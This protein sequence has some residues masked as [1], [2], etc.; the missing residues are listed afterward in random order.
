[1]ELAEEHELFSKEKTGKNKD[2]KDKDWL[3]S[4]TDDLAELKKKHSGK[5]E[6][7][8]LDLAEA[9][10][11]SKDESELLDEKIEEAPITKDSDEKEIKV[12]GEDIGAS[13]VK[14]S[15]F[16]RKKPSR[17]KAVDLEQEEIEPD[18]LA[19]KPV[20]HVKDIPQDVEFDAEETRLVDEKIKEFQGFVDSEAETEKGE[21]EALKLAK[22]HLK[23]ID[24]E[25]TKISK[26]GIG[27][28]KVKKSFFKKE[29]PVDDKDF[30]LKQK[31]EEPDKSMVKPIFRV[32]NLSSRD[33][34]AE[35]EKELLDEKIKGFQRIVDSSVKEDK[36]GAKALKPAKEHLKDRPMPAPE[37]KAKIDIEISTG[38]PL[39]EEDADHEH[40]FFDEEEPSFK[41]WSPQIT[42]KEKKRM[43]GSPSAHGVIGSDDLKS[44]G[45]I[46]LPKEV[47]QTKSV[48]LSDLGFSEKEWEELDF[49]SLQEPFA[50]VEILRE[51][52]SLEKCYFL[53]E[54]MLTEEEKQLLS[55]I[56]GTMA[57][58]D[59]DTF[60]LEEKG[61]EEYLLDRLDQVIDEY[62]VEINEETRNKIFYYLSKTS[63]GLDKIDPLMKDPNIEDISCDGSDVPV[64][65]YHRKYGS[66]KSNVRFNDEDEL[67]SF[68]HKL[69]QK[70]GKHIS[71]AEPMLD[72]TMP[73]GSRIQMTLSDEITAKGS[74]FTIRKFRA[75]PF[76]PPDLIQ[77]NTMSS[78]IIAYMWIAVE[79][80]INTLF[81]G[82]TASGK[83]TALNAL[84][85]F[86]PRESKI[87]SIEETR[88]LNLPHPNWIPGVARSGFGE[89]IADKVVGEI[90]MYDLMKAALR[91]RPEYI[92]VG[93]I[94]GREAYVLFQAMA[95]GH[96]T[97]STAHADSAQS[98][99]HRL[100]GKPIN[101]PRIML[102]SL[103]IVCLHVITR[104]KNI[105]ARRC[106]QVIE[107]IDID[108][109]TKEIL[110]NEVFRW[111][112]IEDKFIYSGKSYVL[113][114]VRAEKDLSREEITDELKNRKKIVEWMNENNIREFREVSNV[115]ARYSEDSAE[116]LKQIEKGAKK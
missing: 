103:D 67:S 29:V 26:E 115:V 51:K 81:A 73:D 108:P 64:F 75:D 74:T 80:G 99:I 17:D 60:E 76:S 6:V 78:E 28:S 2:R 5:L 98:L 30:D 7:S 32:E 25:E 86:I 41:G 24:T 38:V 22:E 13:K 94:R 79:N 70:C 50:H 47:L 14:K 69:A 62:N 77:F 15:F 49:Y 97:Y 106:K 11:L 20:S 91:Q 19:R 33:D 27:V 68:V 55:F 109:T 82:G 56:K 71:I 116:M 39:T 104:V 102:Q 40:V 37:K 88:E 44:V 16:K 18:K 65:L 53:V 58:L 101:I 112:P 45:D 84:S 23:D 48:K 52:E 72:A 107:V 34:L 9:D 113:E 95:T 31:E 111:D 100:E 46:E 42:E 54:T 10:E 12:S 90:N 89:V 85:L 83:T 93:E 61:E 43:I 114:R 3:S 92:L 36:G 105:R 63:L 35:D 59:I 110:T 66:L 21:S 87:V 4:C 57:S 96:A 8:D 1:V